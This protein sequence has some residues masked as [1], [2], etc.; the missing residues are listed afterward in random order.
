MKVVVTWIIGG[1][2]SGYC[3][4]GRPLHGDDAEQHDDDRH[5]HRDDRT[6]DE[7][8]SHDLLRLAGRFARLRG[9]RGAGGIGL[10]RRSCRPDRLKPSTTTCSPG[11]RPSSITHS[12]STRGPTLTLRNA[13]LLSRSTTATL[14]RLCSSCTARCGTRSAPSC[15][16]SSSARGRTGPAGAALG[17]GEHQICTPR[18][19]VV[20]STARSTGPM[21]AR[22]A[23][24]PCRRPASARCPSRSGSGA[25]FGSG[26][27]WRRAGSPPRS[28][29][30]GRGSGRSARWSSAACSR[31]GPT[32]LPGFTCVVPTSP[33]IG[34]VTRV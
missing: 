23:D 12:E 28:R 25:P 18:V 15:V 6:V 27:V 14:Y 3:A 22:S 29:R 33:S 2:I 8:A 31:R 20:G 34:D 16:S 4:I 11:L 10:A 1:T 21:R 30:R 13:T 5:H 19:P 24:G 17:I 7:E 32:R 9:R 26:R